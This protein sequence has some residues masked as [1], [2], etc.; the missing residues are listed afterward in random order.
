MKFATE[1]SR[2]IQDK[3]PH[4]K[5]SYYIYK[6]DGYLYFQD[7]GGSGVRNR[8]CMELFMLADEKFG[9]PDFP[10]TLVLT[11]SWNT[12]EKV[13][14]LRDHLAM[15]EL[16]VLSFSADETLGP[17]FLIPDAY[18]N[19]Y[20]LKQ[21]LGFDQHCRQLAE[22]GN[23]PWTSARI[24]WCGENSN[25][26]AIPQGAPRQ[27]LVK[28]AQAH[29]EAIETG[30]LTDERRENKLSYL[31][32]PDQ[33]LDFSYK[34][35][36]DIESYGY[37]GELKYL[38][39]S[40]RLCFWQERPWREWY[41]EE[42]EPFVHYVPVKRDLSDLVQ[43]Y[44]WLERNPEVYDRIVRNA[45][46]FAAR[47]L[48]TARALE[49]IRTIVT[50][51]SGA[52]EGAIR[53]E[54]PYGQLPASRFWKNSVAAYSLR[55]LPDLYR[56]KFPI[57]RTTRLVTAGSCF[58]QHI[59]HQLK[60]RG[61]V[62]LD[63][64]PAPPGVTPSEAR[65][66]GYG[67]F[68][69]RYGN[70]YTMR[71]LLQLYREC[72]GQFV[73]AAAIWEKNG[74]YYDALRP[75]V[76]PMGY[77]TAE[78]VSDERKR[79]LEKIKTIFHQAEVFIF[80]FG[81][82]EG[83]EHS[84]SGTTYPMAPGTVAGNYDADTFRFKNFNFNEIKQD[85][86]TFRNLLRKNNEGVKFLLTVSPV[87]LVATA[88]E[89]HVLTAS[90]YSKSVLRAVAG[91]LATEYSDIDYFPSFEIITGP[92]APGTFYQENK[93]SVSK[94]GREAVMDAFFQSHGLAE[95][96]VENGEK[97]G[98]QIAIGPIPADE[99]EDID[100]ICDK[101]LLEAF[102]KSEGLANTDYE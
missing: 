69:A 95:K 86:L 64:E 47:Q 28:L 29:P 82:T 84:A 102:G 61:Y 56:P 65:Q 99:I 79:H 11:D 12:L 31:K 75:R 73:P 18:F 85:F 72:L 74:K 50:R 41:H 8:L 90:I 98:G 35:F 63:G 87:H 16:P 43:Q 53:S 9:L 26:F 52:S 1:N 32:L 36:L 67:L 38:L 62:L 58:A 60:Q 92:S 15:P 49:Q 66:R 21:T 22:A 81:L 71:Q 33:L 68:S 4:V 13:V 96:E 44:Q 42:L 5:K 40:K 91:E 27:I 2:F 57:S 14:H 25:Y 55:E 20:H 10:K 101:A 6:E 30:F 3:F 97:A 80:T 46:A 48:N 83:W 100:E 59:T 34:Y 76:E 45:T 24:G 89:D 23:R 94:E 51:L 19:R 54:S 78:L 7:N 37:L 93:R 88:T 70:I 77:A 17:Q 39:F